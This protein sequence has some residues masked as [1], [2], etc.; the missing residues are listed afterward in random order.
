MLA[1]SWFFYNISNR[2][3]IIS[4]GGFDLHFPDVEYLFVSLFI[5]CMSSLD[6]SLFRS[7]VHFY[8]GCFLF[9][10]YVS[11]FIELSVFSCSSLNFFKTISFNFLSK[12]S[13]IS[14]CFLSTAGNVLSFFHGVM[15]TWFYVFPAVLHW[16]LHTGSIINSH[17]SQTLL[18]GSCKEISS[19]VS[20]CHSISVT[21]PSPFTQ[22]TASQMLI[23]WGLQPGYSQENIHSQS[24][25][26]R[27]HGNKSQIH[28]PKAR[29]LEPVE[30]S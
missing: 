2:Y 18:T 14:I 9:M 27:R 29:G 21:R 30:W 6:K 24:N 16:Y 8:L 11:D 23:R 17:F 22:H 12:I 20:G 10:N 5:I 25:N 19:L 3:E 26:V 13:W 4:L 7:L 28:P 1:I 15:F